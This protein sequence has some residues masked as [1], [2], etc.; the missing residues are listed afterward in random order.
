M[1]E[2]IKEIIL[3]YCQGICHLE[4]DENDL[5]EMVGKI[6]ETK[7]LSIADVGK[8]FY[9]YENLANGKKQCTVKCKECEGITKMK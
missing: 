1:E 6:T 2:K 4:F 5:D 8:A 7:Q 9:C 3:S